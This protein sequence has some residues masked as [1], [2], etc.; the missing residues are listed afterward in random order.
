MEVATFAAAALALRFF[1]FPF[2]VMV[3][4]VALWFLSMDL[5]W[6]LLH[7]QPASD[8]EAE[9]D[10]RRNVSMVFGVAMIAVA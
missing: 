4:S 10:F 5:A 6:L 9:W 7:R 1:P 2:I 8:W 3:A